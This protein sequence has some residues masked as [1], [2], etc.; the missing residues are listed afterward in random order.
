MGK[1]RAPSRVPPGPPSG[2]RG[3]PSSR[4]LARP[5]G[6]EASAVLEVEGGEG[7]I[8]RRERS[9]LLN[10][11]SRWGQRRAH[12]IWLEQFQLLKGGVGGGTQARMPLKK[13]SKGSSTG[14]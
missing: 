6:K 8:S 1:K 12:W 5:G 4:G 3:G 7:D 9:P 2:L 13:V 10:V 11:A 14:H